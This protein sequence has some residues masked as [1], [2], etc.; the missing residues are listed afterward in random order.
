MSAA[1]RAPRYTGVRTFAGLSQLSLEQ[2]TAGPEGVGAS[3]ARA[4]VVGV[5]FDTATS[6]RPGAR[7]GPEAIRAAS[8]LLRP[9]HP[10]H[11]VEVFGE[12][13]P[14]FDGGDIAIT[15]GNAE[16]SAEQIAGALGPICATGTTPVV[17][18]GDHSILLGELRAH[19]ATRGPLG[20]L[21][22]DAHADTWD[23]YYGERLFHGTV[24]RRAVEEG[25]LDPT[26]SLIAGLR[27]SLY[28]PADLEDALALG[29]ELIG[30]DELRASEPGEFGARARTRLAG[31]ASFLGFDI[32]VIDPS[33]APGTGTPEVGGLSAAEALALLRALAGV[34]FLGCDVVEVSPP[35][36]S[37]GQI[38]SLLA[39]N[40][41]YEM[42]ALGALSHASD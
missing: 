40:I 1:R 2:L 32:D 10:S 41:A 23:D 11:A 7:F 22:F 14:V 20:L 21:L 37:P 29:F 25:L 4:I 38:T 12:R 24:I 26:R 16:R 18:G 8:S 36:D 6:W 42:L 9:W 5:P 30:I 13:T 3:H 17:L 31:G 34:R 39:A 33:A 27:G 28:E 15:P 19:A 35:Y